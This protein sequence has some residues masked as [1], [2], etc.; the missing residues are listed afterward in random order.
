MAREG[1]RLPPG[2]VRRSEA[3][4]APLLHWRPRSSPAQAST[5]QS[6]DSTFY[7]TSKQ[8]ILLHIFIAEVG[9]IYKILKMLSKKYSEIS[10]KK[11]IFYLPKHERTP[12]LEFFVHCKPVG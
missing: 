10:K 6:P 11:N 7:S 3:L 9:K 8:C 1:M 4:R 5:T 12:V 2:A